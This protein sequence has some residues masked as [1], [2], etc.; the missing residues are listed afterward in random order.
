M[1]RRTPLTYAEAKEVERQNS[2]TGSGWC[3]AA[4]SCIGL[5]T[6]FLEIMQ[7]EDR[8]PDHVCPQTGRHMTYWWAQLAWRGRA[9]A[10]PADWQNRWPLPVGRVA[11]TYDFERWRYPRLR[12]AS[13]LLPFGAEERALLATRVEVDDQFVDVFGLARDVVYGDDGQPLDWTVGSL[14]WVV[15]GGEIPSQGTMNLLR[16]ARRW[17]AGHIEG[18]PRRSSVNA[19]RPKGSVK[20]KPRSAKA[21]L[22]WY[23]EASEQYA[24]DGEQPTLRDLA[25]WMGVKAEKTARKRL[26][27][28]ELSWPPA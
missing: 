25:D 21:I 11:L 16:R 18:R 7:A 17:W 23:R 26:E 2:I 24:E 9:D 10:S 5:L 1:V 20:G 14:A 3:S 13:A 15:Q 22:K 19:G 28:L 6:S 8:W 12:A 27:K 4:P